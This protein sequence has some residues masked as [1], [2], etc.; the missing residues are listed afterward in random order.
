MALQVIDTGVQ[1]MFKGVDLAATHPEPAWRKF[2]QYMRVVTD[3]TFSRLR[4]GGTFRS[5]TW[6]YFAAQY[7]RKD[8]T[9]V[10]AWG[11]IP[12]VRGTGLVLGKKRPSGQRIASGDAI[13]QDTRHMASRAGLVIRQSRTRLELGPQGVRY[14]A[15]QNEDRKFLFFQVEK[16]LPELVKILAKHI[17]TH[18]RRRTGL[19]RLGLPSAFVRIRR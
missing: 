11:G 4:R 9:V 12:K 13:M 15:E 10:P 18:A 6:R 17:Q 3:R 5:V 2:A 7:T 14:A 1:E 16:D 19:R 8:G